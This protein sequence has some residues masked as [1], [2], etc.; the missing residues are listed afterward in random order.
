MGLF[1]KK[2][3]ANSLKFRNPQMVEKGEFR[4]NAVTDLV[5]PDSIRIIGEDAFR[6]CRNLRTVTL[7]PNLCEIGAYAFRDCDALESIIFPDTMRYPDESAGYI[8]AGSFDGCGLLRQLI[9][10]EGVA[11][12]YSNAFHNCAALE[13]VRLP[14]TIRALRSGAF[15]GCARL[16]ELEMPVVPEIIAAD[17]FIDT[18]HHQRITEIRKPVL[19]IAHTSSFGLPEVYQFAVAQRLIGVEQI[20]REMS[21]TLDAFDDERIT[22]RITRYTYA[23]GSHTIPKNQPSTLFHEEYDCSGRTGLQTEE[24]LASYR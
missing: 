19:T 11:I 9:I 8:G 2:N 14:R 4:G 5:F 24:I 6:E 1:S 15:S 13:Y 22:F 23:G 17:A 18:P 7:P 3:N 21:V 16:K 20:D 10:P 12:I